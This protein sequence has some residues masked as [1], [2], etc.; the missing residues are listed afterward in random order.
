M[1]GKVEKSWSTGEYGTTV[2]VKKFAGRRSLYLVWHDPNAP[3]GEKRTKDGTVVSRRGNLR[4]ESLGHSDWDAAK[5]EAKRIQRELEA[6]LEAKRT[7]TLTLTAL[8][9]KYEAGV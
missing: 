9:E 4:K 6:A 1:S 7:G 3:A 5:R 2:S 8:F